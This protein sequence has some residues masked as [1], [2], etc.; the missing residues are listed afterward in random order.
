MPG[1]TVPEPT[2]IPLVDLSRQHA[3]LRAEI[4]AAIASV[5]ESSAFI[6]GPDV[7]GFEREW[8]AFCEARFAIGVGSGTAALRLTLEALGIG[9]GD[10][11]IAPA[12]TF[13]ASVLPV[14]H[15]GA[16]LVLVDCDPRT[17]T[18]DPDAVAAAATE[19]TRAVVAVHLY[20]QP[21]DLDPLL[22]TAD[23]RGFAVIEDAC[24]AHG[25]TYRGRR[26]GAIGRAGCFSFYPSKNLG[27]LGDAGAVV[28]DDEEL[29]ERIRRG[30][31][32][33]QVGKYEHVQL[34]HNERLDTLQ[35]AV[36][37]RKLPLLEGW[38][39]LRRRHADAYRL[40]LSGLELEL[41]HEAEER[42]HVWHLFVV[43][44]SERD[45]LRAV[46]ADAGVATGLHYPVPLHLERVLE[47]LGHGPGDFPAAEDWA[48]RGLSLPMF[49]ELQPAEIERV[50][51]AIALSSRGGR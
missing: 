30:R 7:D 44:T 34:G 22:R 42:E 40:A 29:A 19:R 1:V 18:I 11:V 25:A 21:A 3:A 31:D 33:G 4:D 13:I 32:L 2:D 24:Q 46:L 45:G 27:A 9:P 51:A 35:A 38:N 17:G 28:T 50:A 47:R 41:P 20:G 14:V 10:E 39:E 12:N 43:R 49:P 48:R 16:R 26:V 6:L 37:R 23:E 15:L 8:A 36:L 5:L